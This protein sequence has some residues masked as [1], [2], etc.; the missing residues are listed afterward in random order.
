MPI[1]AKCGATTLLLLQQRKSEQSMKVCKMNTLFLTC[2]TLCVVTKLNIG[3]SGGTLS[4][5]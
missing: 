4:G 1:K 3:S 2:L 5:V